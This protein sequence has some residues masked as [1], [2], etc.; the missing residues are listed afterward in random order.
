MIQAWSPPA[1]SG[2]VPVALVVL[3]LTA[4]GGS[5]P[6]QAAAQ[7]ACTA[8]ADTGRQQAA[9]SV[10]DAD[11]IR[12]TARAEAGKAAAADPE[13]HAL[14]RDIEDFYARQTS[15]RRRPGDMVDYFAADRRVQADCAAAGRDIGPP[16]P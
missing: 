6:G 2:V 3:M 7:Q 11:T 5:S 4:C 15:S 1:C 14:Q 8:F 13:W 10:E 9:T 16:E 12:A